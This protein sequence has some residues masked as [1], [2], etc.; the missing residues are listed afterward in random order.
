MLKKYFIEIISFSYFKAKMFVQT[1][2]QNQKYNQDLITSFTRPRL[3]C[4]N[5][6][7]F[8]VSERVDVT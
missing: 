2:S 3:N 7:K 8:K 1:K 4:S 5:F 6:T